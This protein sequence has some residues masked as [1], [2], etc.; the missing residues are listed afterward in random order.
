[1]AVATSF[2]NAYRI[3]ASETLRT[4]GPYHVYLERIFGSGGD[5]DDDDDEGSKG[6]CRPLAWKEN[7]TTDIGTAGE[8]TCYIDTECNEHCGPCM[9]DDP[10]V[11]LSLL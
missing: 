10:G 2:E 1:M 7:C 8:K 9:P 11:A 4:V 6:K 5:D 3:A